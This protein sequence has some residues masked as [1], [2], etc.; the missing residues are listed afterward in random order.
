MTGKFI[1]GKSWEKQKFFKLDNGYVVR[2]E[3]S[4]YGDI[5]AAIHTDEGEILYHVSRGHDAIPEKLTWLREWIHPIAEGHWDT[6]I[7]PDFTAI[8]TKEGK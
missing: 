4:Y 6:I 2:V 8:Y 5:V 7:R 3:N 1:R